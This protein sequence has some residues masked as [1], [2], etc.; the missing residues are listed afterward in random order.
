MKSG[1]MFA[2]ED[3]L[4]WGGGEGGEGGPEGRGGRLQHSRL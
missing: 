3:A 2:K 4:V 1:S